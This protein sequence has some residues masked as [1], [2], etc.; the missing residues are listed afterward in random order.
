MDAASNLASLLDALPE[1]VFL[2]DHEGVVRYA[3]ANAS[4]LLG[5]SDALTGRRFTLPPEV[6]VDIR[7]G[8][9]RLV[10]LNT[11]PGEWEGRTATLVHLKDV[12][13]I[14]SSR[15]E[16]HTD[17]PKRN[18]DG[19][20]DEI[21]TGVVHN[22]GN[23][24]NSS[25]V[26]VNR[27][28]EGL[29]DLRAPL[30]LKAADLLEKEGVGRSWDEEHPMR[31]L[32]AFLRALATHLERER[33]AL[34]HEARFLRRSLEHI[35]TLVATQQRYAQTRASTQRTTLRD[36]VEIAIDL[37]RGAMES[38]DVKLE[39]RIGDTSDLQVDRNRVIQILLNLLTNAR[40]A[41]K[42]VPGRRGRIIITGG[43]NGPDRV[44]VVVSDNGVGMTAD[45]LRQAFEHGFTTR[46]TGHGFGLASCKRA[47]EEMSGSITARSEGKGR[48]A[49]FIL[50]IP[51]CQSRGE[52]ATSVPS[53][54]ATR[55]GTDTWL[56]LP[57]LDKD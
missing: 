25:S 45:E 34:S 32:P 13:R 12:T 9:D 8:E 38:A 10:E 48:G 18:G 1:G 52:E 2:V 57:I 44:Q 30:M 23:L 15:R 19:E 22:I 20:P 7:I 16:S 56:S 42:A 33:E 26:A 24:L 50:E 43:P 27:I 14:R 31:R 3:N 28:A 6:P 11:V 54:P 37:E 17:Q 46:R 21:T 55:T 39:C 47:A 53:R 41:V 4:R 36:L 29:R 40:H 51:S 35:R 49:F 5:A